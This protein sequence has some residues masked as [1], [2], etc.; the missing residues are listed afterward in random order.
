MGSVAIKVMLELGEFCLQ[1]WR[2]PEKVRA[3]GQNE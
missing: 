3:G 1:I 2:R